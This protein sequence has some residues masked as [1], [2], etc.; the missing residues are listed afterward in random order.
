MRTVWINKYL[1]ANMLHFELL[2]HLRDKGLDTNKPFSRW[3]SPEKINL[4]G[5]RGIALP[6]KVVG[7]IKTVI[8]VIPITQVWEG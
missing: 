1:I 7:S 5:Y 3:E 4:Q 8:G 6:D 2:E